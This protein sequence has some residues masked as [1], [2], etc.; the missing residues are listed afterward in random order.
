MRVCRSSR[1]PARGSGGCRWPTGRAMRNRA[2][3]TIQLAVL[4]STPELTAT[5]G[6]VPLLLEEPDPGGQHGHRP[7][8]QGDEGVGQL[9][10][11]GPAVGKGVGDRAHRGDGDGRVG[12]LGQDE[13]QGHPGPVGPGDG[14]PRLGH[15]DQDPDEGPAPDEGAD[16]QGERDPAHPPGLDELGHLDAGGRRPLLAHGGEHGLLAPQRSGGHGVEGGPLEERAGRRPGP[17]SASTGGRRPPSA[18]GRPPSAT[19]AS[20]AAMSRLSWSGVATVDAARKSMKPAPPCVVD[21]DGLG[22]ERP[23]AIPPAAAPSAGS[24][25]SSSASS[26]SSRAPRPWLRPSAEGADDLRRSGSGPVAGAVGV[27]PAVGRLARRMARTG[28]TRRAG[29]PAGAG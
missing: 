29:R 27:R 5:V 28:R 1:W 3:L 12:R 26:A 9:E 6:A 8:G 2:P 11:Q 22:R 19:A 4:T 10:G 23:W 18:P 14:A 15:V 25:T 17:R 13:D 7:A 21:H 20:A 16:D 24:K